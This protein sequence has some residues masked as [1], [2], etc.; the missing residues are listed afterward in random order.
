M[1][2]RMRT[3]LLSTTAAERLGPLLSRDRATLLPALLTDTNLHFPKLTFQHFFSLRRWQEIPADL[4]VG[5][6]GDFQA[7]WKAPGC[8][9]NSAPCKS[10]RAD[11]LWQQNKY[12]AV[13]ATGESQEGHGPAGHG[14]ISHL[15]RTHIGVARGDCVH[16]KPFAGKC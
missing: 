11:F 10:A 3:I 12:P 9:D 16:L 2:P 6:H 15:T 13:M 7:P 8:S 5:I 4:F 1:S 14:L